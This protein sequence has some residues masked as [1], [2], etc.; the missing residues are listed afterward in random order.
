MKSNSKNYKIWFYSERSLDDL[1]EIFFKKGLIGEFECDYENVYEWI[2]A[3]STNSSVEFNISRKHS[4]LQDFEEGSENQLKSNLE[5]PITL[6]LMYDDTEPSDIEI[7][8]IA[9]QINLILTTSV[10]LGM[11]NYLGG[12]DYE[13]LKIKEIT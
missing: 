11:V 6:M 9:N 5:E 13:Y 7:E 3:K 8:T 2:E 1:A 12:D 4:Y 10:Y